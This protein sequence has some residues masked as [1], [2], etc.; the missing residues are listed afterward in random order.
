MLSSLL[1]QTGAILRPAKRASGFGTAVL[2]DDWTNPTTTPARYRMWQ[3]GGTERTD[4]RDIAIG[5]W[6]L[7]LFPD[8]LISEKDRFVS[9]T[10][11]TFEVITVYPA[12]TP[13]GRHHIECDLV[14]FSGKAPRDG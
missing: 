12:H 6:R 3:V 4:L 9:D 1:S 11:D 2:V 5:Q 13:G 7:M 8:A 10:G 14:T